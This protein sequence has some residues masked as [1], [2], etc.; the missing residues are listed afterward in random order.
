MTVRALPVE[1]DPSERARRAR[2]LAFVRRAL[3]VGGGDVV[4]VL[5]EGS[6]EPVVLLPLGGEL[7]TPERIADEITSAVGDDAAA[8]R[9][10]RYRVCIQ[11]GDETLGT[12]SLRVRAD[13]TDHPLDAQLRRAG[14]SAQDALIRQLMRHQESFV[15]LV[16]DRDLR[17]AEADARREDRIAARLE[18]LER[19]AAEGADRRVELLRVEHEL[20][21]D[22]ANAERQDMLAREAVRA[23]GPAA[24]QLGATVAR[25]LGAGGAPSRPAAPAAPPDAADHAART[26]AVLRGLPPDAVEALAGFVAPADA[27]ALRAA[28]QAGRKVEPGSDPA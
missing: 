7:D 24:A 6:T 23:L 1:G 13:A 10:G 2:V 26:L 20:A 22:L 21:R 15:R 27:D 17:R 11:R 5:A 25:R 16:M 28:Y 3:A 12:L 14:E 19:R 18:D 4:V 9:V 8:S